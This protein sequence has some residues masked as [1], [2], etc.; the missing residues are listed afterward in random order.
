MPIGNYN[1][2]RDVTLTVYGQN[3][4][5]L[6]LNLITDFESNQ[7]THDVQ[8]KGMDGVVRH[9]ML[10]N[11]WKGKF[12]LTRANSN[13]DDYFA[14][15]E[16]NYYGGQNVNYASIMETVVNPDG[17]T[18]QFQFTGVMMKLSN[19]GMWKGDSEVKQTIDFVASRRQKIS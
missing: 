13:L 1:V 12:D 19:A 2:G 17:S 11:G 3:G 16:S 4:G 15:I 9:L 10:P 6:A 5:V 18:S 8:V 7:E 14:Q